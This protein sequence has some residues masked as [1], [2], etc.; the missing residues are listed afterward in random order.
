MYIPDYYKNENIDEV[1]EF[2]SKNSFAILISSKDGKSL[3]S[4]IPLELEKD[5]N[6]KD[7][8]YGHI[9]KANLQKEHF[10]ENQQVLAIFSGPNAYVS[11][12]WYNHENVPTWNYIAVHIYGS[13]EIIQQEELM[14]ALT[15]LV[16]KY[17]KSST[18]P[19]S[20]GKMS[21]KI[22]EQTKGIVGFKIIITEI[23]AAYKLSQNRNDEDYH[24]VIQKL[25]ETEISSSVELVAEMKKR[26]LI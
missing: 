4:H 11:S 21:P 17:E 25:N 8:L 10:S 5:F 15:K 19:A 9:S 22:L 12:S 14:Y 3:G 16:D 1:K 6:D 24:T 13:I 23:H 18:N 2:I 7:V 20:V 26:R